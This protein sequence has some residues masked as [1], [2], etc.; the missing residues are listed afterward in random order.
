MAV[1][2]YCVQYECRMPWAPAHR[3]KGAVAKEFG[4]YYVLLLCLSPLPLEKILLASMPAMVA[5]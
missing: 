1:K 4:A 2:S 3:R 5:Q